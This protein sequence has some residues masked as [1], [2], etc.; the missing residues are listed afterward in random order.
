M[1]RRTYYYYSG[2]RMVKTLQMARLKY[3]IVAKNN[4]NAQTVDSSYPFVI[5]MIESNVLFSKLYF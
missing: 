2:F 1:C 4:T 3:I 5:V